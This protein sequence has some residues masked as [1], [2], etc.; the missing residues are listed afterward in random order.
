MKIY[1]IKY[2]LLNNVLLVIIK[3]HSHIYKRSKVIKSDV[4]L[5]SNMLVKQSYI[6]M[7]DYVNLY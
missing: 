6:R 3:G 1:S 2:E 4:N 7:Y 5:S